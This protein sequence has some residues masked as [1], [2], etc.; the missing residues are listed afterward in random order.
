MKILPGQVLEKFRSDGRQVILRI[1]KE[2]D[3]KLCFEHINSLIREKTYI[4]WQKP[5]T[6]RQESEWLKKHLDDIRTG[7]GVTV[8]VEVEGKF[9]GIGVV[10]KEPFHAKIHRAQLAIGLSFFRGLGIGERLMETLEKMAKKHLKAKILE[11]TVYEPNIVAKSLYEKCG[12]VEAGRIPDGISY[13]G[14]YFDEIIMIKK[15]R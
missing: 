3:L 7:N 4:H 1:I 5:F 2:S 15:L 9:S 14:R 13:Y 10:W 6:M 11:L 8:A 12:F